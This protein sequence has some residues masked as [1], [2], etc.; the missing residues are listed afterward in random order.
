MD[1]GDALMLWAKP[2]PG[3]AVAILLVNNHPTITYTDVE[4]SASEVGIEAGKEVSVRDI[5]RRADAGK[6]KGG[7]VQLTVPPRDSVFL[8]LT[9]P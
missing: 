5:W 2:Q 7:D 6:S 3:G 1:N 8:L 4:I 9:P